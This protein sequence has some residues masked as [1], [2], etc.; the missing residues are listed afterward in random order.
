MVPLIA[1]GGLYSSS[2]D[3][4]SAHY[5]WPIAPA[6]SNGVGGWG[7]FR[8]SFA[9]CHRRVLDALSAGSRRADRRD[10]SRPL[11]EPDRKSLAHPGRRPGDAFLLWVAGRWAEM[12]R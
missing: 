8:R 9:T 1:L 6:G 11:E 3:A 12:P 7:Q 2:F 4:E 5:S 10:P